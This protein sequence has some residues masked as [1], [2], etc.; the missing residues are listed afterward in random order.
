[1]P[2][3]LD[4]NAAHMSLQTKVALCDSAGFHSQSRFEQARF[5]SLPIHLDASIPAGKVKL[6]REI[7]TLEVL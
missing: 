6:V 4:A 3:L 7:L 2:E 1:M 5:A